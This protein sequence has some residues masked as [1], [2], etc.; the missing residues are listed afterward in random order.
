MLLENALVQR[1]QRLARLDPELV[2][3]H[4][5]P[6]GERVERLGLASRAVQG[7]HQ[8]AAKTLTQ[9]MLRDE[10]LQLGDDLVVATEREP[11]VEVILDGG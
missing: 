3:E 2:D 1:P 4:A 10:R 7:E 8:L 6:G 9:G 11:R 5:A